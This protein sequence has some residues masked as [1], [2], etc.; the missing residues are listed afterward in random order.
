MFITKN[1]EKKKKIKL[2]III[3]PYNI[4]ISKPGGFQGEYLKINPYT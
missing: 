4:G 1:Q 3:N 2:K